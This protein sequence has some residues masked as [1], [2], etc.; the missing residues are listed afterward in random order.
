[1]KHL[2]LPISPHSITTQKTNINNYITFEKITVK[3]DTLVK[4]LHKNGV[5][6]AP[7]VQKIEITFWS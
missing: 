6:P 4:Y 2:Y 7:V 5:Y 1:M 3:Q